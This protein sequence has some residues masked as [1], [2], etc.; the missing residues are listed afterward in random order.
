M[1]INE[2]DASYRHMCFV[3]HIFLVWRAIFEKWYKTW[4]GHRSWKSNQ[5]LKV[6]EFS[7][8]IT[9]KAV[10][11]KIYMLTVLQVLPSQYRGQLQFKL[12]IVRHS[13]IFLYILSSCLHLQ[14]LK[15]CSHSLKGFAINMLVY[16][17][18]QGNVS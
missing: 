6:V 11:G 9:D 17:S 14:H 2:R 16:S 12:N 7:N 18:T 4:F 10:T 5:P 13:H 1:P 15:I 3:M 8:V